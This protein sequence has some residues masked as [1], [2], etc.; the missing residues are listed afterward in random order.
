MKV[1]VVIPA[2]N[3]AAT[4]D[5]AVESVLAQT[6]VPDE[7][8]ILDD[9]STDDTFRHL[10]AHQSRATIFRQSNHGVAHARNYL[11]QLAKGEIIAFLDADDVWHPQY[12]QT[13]CRQLE[14][15]P[16]AAASFTG[17]LTFRG[18]SKYSWNGPLP[19]RLRDSEVIEPAHFLKRYNLCPGPF[20]SMS[21]CCIPKRVLNQ[22][23]AE[24]FPAKLTSA[25]DFC[26]MNL[27]P[28]YGSIIYTAAPLVAYRETPGS[29]SSNRLECVRLAVRAFELLADTYRKTP[30]GRKYAKIFKTAFASKR[31]HYAKFLMGAGQ[32]S[33][34]KIQLKCSLSDAGSFLSLAKSMGLLLSAYLP[35]TLQPRWP[36]S[37][38]E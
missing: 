29:L 4:I 28:L 10:Q 17:H 33:E 9:G 26:L 14:E 31:R 21:F 11:C 2:Y 32:A 19:D 38:R 25:E 30:A 3:A 8:L 5:A 18:P 16:R 24:P 1:S 23:G 15:H 37:C 22:V 34:A 35:A 13:Q 7:I 20:G 6:V 12:L 36:T 27:L